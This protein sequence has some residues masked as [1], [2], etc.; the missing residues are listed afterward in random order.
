MPAFCIAAALAFLVA[1]RSYQADLLRSGESPEAQ[2]QA[3]SE[4]SGALA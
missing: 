4:S 2:A 3:A 1:A